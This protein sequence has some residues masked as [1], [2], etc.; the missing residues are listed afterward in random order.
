MENSQ[1]EDRGS[2]GPLLPPALQQT[3]G[4]KMAATS[5]LSSL[6]KQP[7]APGVVASQQARLP[8]PLL[9][10]TLPFCSSVTSSLL[11]F[12]VLFKMNSMWGP[13][14]RPSPVEFK[15]EP[16][17]QGAGVEEPRV[18][19]LAPSPLRLPCLEKEWRK[20]VELL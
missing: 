1:A 3:E 10:L 12:R 18:E 6:R 15:T 11:L 13:C 9:P 16:H 19:G 5:S 7:S 2:R 14:R 4:E 20:G 8:P 17:E